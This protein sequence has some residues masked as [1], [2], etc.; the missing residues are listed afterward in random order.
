MNTKAQ[1]TYEELN[2]C[3][4]LMSVHI[5]EAVAKAEQEFMVAYQ[6]EMKKVREE[7]EELKEKS[8]LQE[9]MIGNKQTLTYL[10]KQVVIFREE[11]LL[12]Y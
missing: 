12:L 8:R 2:S 5:Q 1:A 11:S 4:D 6:A 7:L 3:I 10:Q 9:A